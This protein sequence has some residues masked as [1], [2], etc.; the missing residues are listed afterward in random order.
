MSAEDICVLFGNL[1]DN[2]IFA[3]GQTYTKQITLTIQPQD[4]YVSIVLSNSIKEGMLSNNPYLKTTKL[5]KATHGY[6]IKNIKKVV[7]HY[8]GLIRFYENNSEFVSDILL[9]TIPMQE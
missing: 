7:Q 3:A 6:G 8:H 5:N 9:L 2:A 4:T 1:L